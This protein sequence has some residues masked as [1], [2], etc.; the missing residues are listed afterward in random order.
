MENE[1]LDMSEL[2]EIGR[3]KSVVPQTDAPRFIEV[4]RP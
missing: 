3:T 1:F 4:D 2:A